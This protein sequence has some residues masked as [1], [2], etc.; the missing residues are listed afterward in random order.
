MSEDPRLLFLLR[1]AKARSLWVLVEPDPTDLAGRLTDV[2]F[3]Y[4]AVP[5]M[6][7]MK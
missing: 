7:E 1:A 3:T 5:R 6:Q 2:A 4:P